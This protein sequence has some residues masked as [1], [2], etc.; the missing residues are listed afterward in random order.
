[1]SSSS[2]SSSQVPTKP[3]NEVN[4]LISSPFLPKFLFYK[5]T[6]LSALNELF[7][8]FPSLTERCFK[9]FFGPTGL[10]WILVSSSVKWDSWKK[11]VVLSPG[12]ALKFPQMLLKISIHSP[13]PQRFWYG[14]F[15]I[16]PNHPSF[17]KVLQMTVMCS[18]SFKKM[19]DLVSP[20]FF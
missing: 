3:K 7:F 10:L 18:Q 6:H 19:T 5:H 13:S 20:G 15:G 14:C 11:L 1:M 4:S 12:C 17:L 8:S 9:V 16:G 2:L